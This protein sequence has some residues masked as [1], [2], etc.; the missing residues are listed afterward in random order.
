MSVDEPK[1]PSVRTAA[2]WGMAAQYVAFIAQFATSVIISRFFLSP[3]EVGLFGTALAAAMMVAIFQDFGISRYVAGE[4]DLDHDKLRRCFS[5]SI[6]FALGVGGIILALAWPAALFYNDLRLFPILAVIAASYLLVPFGIVP[7]ALLQRRLDFRG[8]FFVNTGAAL[9]MAIVTISF[10]AAGWSAMSM[11]IGTVAQAAARAAIG[12]AMSGERPHL[13]L[14]L[15]GSQSI[16]EF[17][18]QSSGLSLSGALGMRSPE[19][20]ISRLLGFTAVGLYGRAVG[21]SGQLRQLVSGAIGGVFFPAFARMRDRGEPFAPAY[22]R[23]VSAYSVTTWPAMAFLAAAAVP[24]VAL[25]YGPVWAGVAP[26]LMLVALSEIAFT[27]L[28]LH[29]DVPIV[30]GRMRTLLMLNLI[31]TAIS[32]IL[33]VVA[34]LVSIE[35]AAASR[36]GYGILW[37]AVYAAFMHRLIGFRWRAMLDVYAKSLAC[38][39]ATVAPLLLAYRGWTSPGSISFTM[40]ATLALAGCL[41]WAAMLFVVRHPAR[42]E[43]IEMAEA[44]IDRVRLRAAR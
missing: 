13:P 3:G 22:M 43:F 7:A 35:W 8:L 6:V 31:D 2:A 16:L 10:A 44:V 5:V 32:V 27:A 30:L 40:L 25:L 39:L 23:V 19:L 11:A 42:L 17:G 33:L 28:P 29:M 21:L 15:K 36:I 26:L 24:V 20:I 37:Y 1:G 12:Q 38:T 34:A 41:C 4:A 18:S 14:T 9:A